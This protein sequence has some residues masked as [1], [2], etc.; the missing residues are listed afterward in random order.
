MLLTGSARR[1]E[2]EPL[3]AGS[4]RCTASKTWPQPAL[5]NHGL[6]AG[7]LTK[8]WAPIRAQTNLLAFLLAGLWLFEGHTEAHQPDAQH[9]TGFE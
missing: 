8:R 9:R 6:A 1:E 2:K 3:E 4:E 5:A 7:A